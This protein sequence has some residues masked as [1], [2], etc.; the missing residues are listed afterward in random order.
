MLSTTSYESEN[1]NNKLPFL[2]LNNFEVL[3]M[4]STVATGARS[5]SYSPLISNGELTEWETYSVNNQQWIQKSLNID[6]AATGATPTQAANI[7]PFI[8]QIS[9]KADN[10]TLTMEPVADDLETY[11][12]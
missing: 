1:P 5:V 2:T 12:P 4:H 8:F 11:S 3:G 6:A 7:T 10:T 9:Y